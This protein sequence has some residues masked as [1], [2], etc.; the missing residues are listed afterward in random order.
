MKKVV[1]LHITLMIVS[2][3]IVSCSS[4]PKNPGDIYVLRNQAEKE[5][6]VG[7]REAGRGNFEAALL[8]LNECKR[9]AV[10]TDDP[11]L[12]IRSGLSRGNVLFSLDSRD[13]AFSEWEQSIALAQKYEDRELLSVSRIYNARGKLISNSGSAQ[14]A[15]DEVNREA[16]NIKS[17]QLF[18]AFSW[19]VKGLA[20]RQLGSYRDAEDAIKRSL[21]IHE[22]NMYLENASYDWY[23]IASIR[24][25]AGNTQGA[26][27]ALESA[28]AIDRRIENS[29]GLAAG[30]RAT[31]DVYRKTGKA[32][33]ARDAYQRA[34]AI[35]K[36]IGNEHEAAEAEKRMNN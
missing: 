36:A 20:L 22:K 1:I 15:L 24:S 23:V 10:L 30:W 3:M 34:I 2:L 31:G 8:I 7:N 33:E 13:E 32:Q 25:L 4:Q 29:W 5:L 35:Y 6:D 18:V 19:H 28:V 21:D 16:G 17:N 26:L 14:S 12:L 11:G 27:Q 9:K